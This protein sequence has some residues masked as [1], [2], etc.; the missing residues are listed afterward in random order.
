M[1]E[2]VFIYVLCICK[3]VGMYVFLCIYA[4][5][6]LVPMYVSIYVHIKSCISISMS[7]LCMYIFLR[8][9][10]SIRSRKGARVAP[11]KVSRGRLTKSRPGGRSGENTKS[12]I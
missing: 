8:I 1:Y 9:C 6:H 10:L 4:S 3:Y 11:A 5:L 7:T 2:L 12:N